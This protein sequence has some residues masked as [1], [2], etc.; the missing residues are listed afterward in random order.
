M[1]EPVTLTAG[2]LVGGSL[3]ERIGGGVYV[4]GFH[5]FVGIG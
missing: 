4:G 3:T 5:T 2:V 1:V